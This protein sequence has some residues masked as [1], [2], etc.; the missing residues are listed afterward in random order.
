MKSLP[1]WIER[2]LRAI[3]PDE[4]VDQIV[5][6]LIELYNNDIKSIG[7][8]AAKRKLLMAAFSF[9]RPGILL[10]NRYSVEFIQT[11]M[12]RNYF[13][14]TLRHIKR[15]KINF[16]FKIAGLSLAIF[17]CLAIGLYVSYQLSFDKFHEDYQNI[18]RVNSERKENGV[19][20]K[21]GIVPL[22][23]GPILKREVPEIITMTR[24]RYANGTYLQHDNKVINCEGLIEADTS[25]FN[26]L[27]VEFIKGNENALNKPHSI[28][29]TRTM[30]NNIFGT[31][32][33][34]EETININ[35]DNKVYEV[36]A[37]IEDVKSNSHLDFSAIIPI[38]FEPDFNTKSIADPVEFVD[39]SA[40]LY[41]RLGKPY[42]E[43]LNAKIE[44]ILNR[45][46][47]K[48]DQMESGFSL[49]FQP[50]ADIYLAP[51]LR[52]E[53]S[54]KGSKVYV[55]AFSIL[56]L[57]LLMV[58]GINYVN[59]SIADFTSRS[60]ET[61]VRR[62]LGARKYQLMTQ[63]FFETAIFGVI[64]LVLGLGMLYLLFPQILQ[65]LDS[66]LRLKMLLEPTT[67][68]IVAAVLLALISLSAWP[69][70]RQFA[71]AGIDRNLRV[72]GSSFNSSLSQFLLFTQFA[73][74]SIC[75]GCT[76][77]VGEQIG[78][79]HNKELGFDRKNLLVLSM[80]WEFTV[81]K[82]QTYKHELKQIAGVTEVSNS[83]FR[84]GSGYWKDWY[85]VEDKSGIK[86]V[87]LYEV[88]S[89][90]DLFTTL[91][92]K[93]L[94]GRTYNSSIPSD[95]GAAF[96][97]NE[98]AA[99]E[100]GWDDP[101][102]K[103]IYT[104][105][106]EKGKWDGTVVGV[107]SDINISPLY[108]KVRPLVMR[109][110]WQSE[111]PDGFIYIRYAGDEKAIVRSVEAKYKAL[112]PGYPLALRFVDELY[113]SQHVKEE[114][115]FASVRFGTL[116]IIAVSAL[117]IFSMAAFIS[118]RRMKE[119]GIRKVLGASVSQIA[120]LHI[121]Y[122]LRLVLI[123]NVI[124]LPIAYYLIREWL[125]NFAYRTDLTATPFLLAGVVCILLV[126][127]AGGYS[128]WTS[129]RI[130]PIEIIKIE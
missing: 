24:V 95:S 117:G 27:K 40:I 103:R 6:D 3:C 78:F 98:T 12:L 81:K 17:S 63:I 123:A 49:S 86:Q 47:N 84:I 56:G 97:I 43:I 75:I 13:L 111:Y 73:I 2:F 14:T 71:T 35:L 110:P 16:I 83:S 19:M 39:H 18:Y 52:Y 109:L 90:D 8:R 105:P 106:E 42:T 96:V 31:T 69:P 29:L 54:G 15:G 22:A 116:T 32:D 93:V 76:W 94:A 51:H 82:M 120:G 23:L 107:V 57:L 21:F 44:A 100:L 11:P 53:Y 28:V 1:K 112:M 58:A 101:I 59:L 65:Q 4:M 30:A 89:D 118:I 99:R 41:V 92:V 62:V 77:I 124:S 70:A 126:I 50:I 127:L 38:T 128:A 129:G 113:N 85:F 87:E 88:F 10:R 20:Q 33:V 68:I 104:H 9:A 36:S 80:P 114:K 79:I 91:G 37:V 5:G 25:V 26:L 61:G 72:K 74:S 108:E 115:V 122:F 55:Y 34:L 119:F 46:I 48:A 121:G 67:G 66:N 45:H 130:N 7:E 125:N 102:G 60:R 64:S